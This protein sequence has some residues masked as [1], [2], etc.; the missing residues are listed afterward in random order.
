VQSLAADPG[1][2]EADRR[3]DGHQQDAEQNRTLDQRGSSFI[4]PEPFES[5]QRFA[6]D[7]T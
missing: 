2:N 5:D 3:D 1:A 6:H 4:F 7:S